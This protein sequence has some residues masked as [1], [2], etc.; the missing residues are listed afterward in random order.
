MNLEAGRYRFLASRSIARVTAH[1]PG[2]L[3]SAQG[4]GVEGEVE[5]GADRVLS[6]K[7]RFPLEKLDAGD[8]LSNRELRKFLTLEKRP[9]AEAT[10]VA[11]VIL[12][13]SSAIP[14]GDGSIDFTLEA[15]RMRA[16]IHLEGRPPLVSAAFSLSFTGLSFEPPKLLF[17]RVKDGL[18]VS[19]HGELVLDRSVG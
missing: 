3:F 18:D 2:H 7:A 1:A 12:D 4:S 15:R 16:R 10:L 8:L 11:P 9:T 17:L 13:P 14:S 6:V 19:I 5:L